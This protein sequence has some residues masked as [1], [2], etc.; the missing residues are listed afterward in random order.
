MVQLITSPNT[1][2]SSHM[3][4]FLSNKADRIKKDFLNTYTV[5]F[6]TQSPISSRIINYTSL[7]FSTLEKT[8][9]QL[10]ESLSI[11][12]QEGL[13]NLPLCVQLF[14]N[15]THKKT[16]DITFKHLRIYT[17]Q[18]IDTLVLA[19][20]YTQEKVVKIALSKS[21]G[22]V[23]KEEII[24]MFDSAN[25]RG[26]KIEKNLITSY[27]FSSGT[28]DSLVIKET[29]KAAIIDPDTS[30]IIKLSERRI[31]QIRVNLEKELNTGISLSEVEKGF[32]HCPE[33][34]QT[35]L[36]T[37]ALVV[38]SNDLGSPAHL[39]PEKVF[40]GINGTYYLKKVENLTPEDKV[41]PEKIKN[42]DLDK[43]ETATEGVFKPTDQEH[44]NNGGRIGFTP[45]KGAL[46]ERIAYLLSQELKM[47]T[48]LDFGV[49]PTTLMKFTS[50]RM[51]SKQTHLFGSL[52]KYVPN[53]I[54]LSEAGRKGFLCTISDEEKFKLLLDIPLLN[55]D[56]HLSNAL[57][58]TVNKKIILIDHG[59][60]LPDL[61]GAHQGRLLWARTAL[62]DIK[63]SDQWRQSLAELNISKL[64]KNVKKEV[65]NQQ[66]LFSEE[67]SQ[68][69]Q[70]KDELFSTLHIG[71]AVL[72]SGA[73]HDQYL[74]EFASHVNNPPWVGGNGKMNRFI[75]EYAKDKSYDEIQWDTIEK[76]I[77]TQ[78]ELKSSFT[79]LNAA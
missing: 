17:Q 12:V 59:Y 13:Y 42:Y 20:D 74:Y 10:L 66:E 52:Q 38:L 46:R 78:I 54:S 39:H 65:E 32:I 22:L 67:I 45:G 41:S 25:Q 3:E 49:P 36:K 77:Q 1:L 6:K 34:K 23:S 79:S 64:V 8:T 53:C 11:K 27:L 33:M 48:G 4:L 43:I 61:E 72:K 18:L 16:E 35:V 50:S 19:K 44:L 30:Q 57:Y 58:D 26:E 71:L 24:Q 56:R 37:H 7:L 69:L 63:L 68:Q 14:F 70:V 31:Q 15:T 73:I 47:A 5:F 2:T 9:T 60:C 51:G 28:L 75:Q 76:E 40:K 62:G 55:T 29:K 21:K